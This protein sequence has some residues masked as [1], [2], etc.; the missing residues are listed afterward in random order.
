MT[1]VGDV[2]SSNGVLNDNTSTITTSTSLIRAEVAVLF[3]YTH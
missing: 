2:V 1:I 3:S